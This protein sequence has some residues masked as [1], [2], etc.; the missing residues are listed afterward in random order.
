MA[1]NNNEPIAMKFNMEIVCTQQNIMGYMNLENF[2]KKGVIGG[3][4]PCK[5]FFF[6]DYNKI[7]DSL[8]IL[9]EYYVVFPKKANAT[10]FILIKVH[11]GGLRAPYL[12]T[13]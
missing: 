3:N 13:P 5:M 4:P 12:Q 1:L 8:W 11:L 7:L 10:I 9:I 2:L 6:S